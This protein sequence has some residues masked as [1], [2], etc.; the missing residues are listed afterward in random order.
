MLVLSPALVTFGGSRWEHVT[1][2]SIDRSA[3]RVALEWTDAGAHPTL[4][5]VPEQR[6]TV[7]VVQRVERDDLNAPRPGDAGELVLYT[8]PGGGDAGRRKVSAPAVVTHVE[9]DVTLRRGAQRV[10]RLVAVS[11]DGA[12]DPV[13]VSDAGGGEA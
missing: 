1:L 10:I 4:A 9:H 7:R 2:V 12:A 6:V 3:E 5:D 8:S 13:T 11:A